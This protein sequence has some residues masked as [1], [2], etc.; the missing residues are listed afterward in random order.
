MERPHLSPLN[1][2]VQGSSVEELS[3]PDAPVAL[4]DADAPPPPAAAA[5]KPEPV[6]P[7]MKQVTVDFA[8]RFGP[9]S[10]GV[11]WEAFVDKLL[12]LVVATAAE[13]VDSDGVESGSAEGWSRVKVLRRALAVLAEQVRLAGSK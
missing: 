13:P 8:S 4:S 2:S 5:E 6:R 10:R 1:L 7:Q 11:S 3:L 12:E 9:P